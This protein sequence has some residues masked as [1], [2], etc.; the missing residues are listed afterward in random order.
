MLDGLTYGNFR[1][2]LNIKENLH[3]IFKSGTGA[4]KSGSF[5]FSSK[6]DNFI[7][8]TMRGNEKPMLL[9]LLDGMIK[10]FTDTDNM[11]LLVRFYGMFTIK[12][13]MF[14]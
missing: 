1:S 5:F 7:I 14:Q 11:S 3:N 10:H 12:T 13:N 8:K 2:S 4:G 9:K 6:D